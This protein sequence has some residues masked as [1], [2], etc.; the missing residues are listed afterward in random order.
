[1]K[2]CML[3]LITAI[4]VLLGTTLYFGNLLLNESSIEDTI[5]YATKESDTAL[6][7]GD[8]LA[9]VI[10]KRP[11][12]SFGGYYYYF[13]VK[14]SKDTFPFIQKYTP[15][16]DSDKDK[17]DKIEGLDEC[18][19]DSYVLTLRVGDTIKYLQFN[20]YDK[21]TNEVDEKVLKTCKRGR[22]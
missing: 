19:G 8:K 9:Y 13:G 7:S 12:G 2:Q 10:L 20:P 18:E 6:A 16:L 22:P 14:K 3:A 5:E 4:L 1:M 17:F 15:V 11:K 21:N